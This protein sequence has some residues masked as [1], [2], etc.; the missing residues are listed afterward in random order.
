MPH[1]LCHP[2]AARHSGL[3]FLGARSDR[4]ERKGKQMEESPLLA[5]AVRAVGRRDVVGQV[6]EDG[7]TARALPGPQGQG[8]SR[9]PPSQGLLCPL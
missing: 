2:V 6:V 7:E 3:A 4:G 1:T 8:A 5:Q 9:D